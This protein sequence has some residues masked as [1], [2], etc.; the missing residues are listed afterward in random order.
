MNPIETAA[1]DYLEWMEVHNYATTTIACRSR[2]LAYFFAFAHQHDVDEA[3]EVTL[4]LL[5][6]YQHTLF[7]HRK[8]DG[9]PLSFGTQAQ[10]LVPVAQFFSWLR[11]EHRIVTNPAADLLMPRPDRRLP[12]ATLS[13]SE[14]A[15]LLSAPDVSKPLGLRD[16]AVL[17]VFYSCALRRGELI[18]LWFRD[19]DFERST[20]FVRRGK[21]A[22]D[23]YVPIGER[24]LFWVRLYTEIVRP[25]F[26]TS[27][28]PDQLFLSSAGTPL[29]P[30]WLCR[31]VRT[32]LAQAGI[33]KRGSCHLLRHTVATLMLE[34]G[35]DIRY[36]AEMLGHSR[37]E[38][39]Q[40]YTRVSIDRL[41]AVHAACHPATGLSVAMASELCGALPNARSA[42]AA[43]RAT[44]GARKQA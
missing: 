19:V 37:L 28:F 35:A 30:D 40:R 7:A 32:Y 31:K 18:S 5:L 33:S 9:E 22:K 23:R 10:R 12:E 4:E 16:R 17:E 43:S 15:A 41:R 29:C 1:H 2:Y 6:G 14:M 27:R 21:G 13:A 20:I 44:S 36:V 38:T 25:G 26:V 34:G 3:K 39:T 24:A 8:R 11:R 42:I